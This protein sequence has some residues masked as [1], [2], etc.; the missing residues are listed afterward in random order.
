M[1]AH[2]EETTTRVQ[3]VAAAAEEMSVNMVAAAAE[4]MSA[5]IAEIASNTEKNKCYH[6]YSCCSI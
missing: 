1:S 2:S 3:T 5:T 4:E 6:Q